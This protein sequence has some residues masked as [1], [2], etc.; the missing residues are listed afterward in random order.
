MAGSSAERAASAASAAPADERSWEGP[1]LR[2]VHDVRGPKV[3]LG[4]LWFA[5]SL[6]AAWLG[7]VALAALFGALAAVAALQSA[8]AWRRSSPRPHRIVAALTGLALPLAALAGLVAVPIAAL[9]AAL[10]AVVVAP[11]GV[12]RAGQSAGGGRAGRPRPMA[13][14]LATL[15]CGLLPA[16][17]AAAIVEVERFGLESLL[18]LLCLVAVY[19]AGDFLVGSGAANAVEGPL[20]GSIGVLVVTFTASV[21]EPAP[22]SAP[23]VWG[24]GI[25]TALIAP[26]GQLA[27]SAML[28]SGGSFA[29]ALRRIDSLLLVAPTWLVFTLVAG[30]GT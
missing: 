20:A 6:G 7:P 12:G 16:L 25:A 5:L 13:G 17:A 22:L 19:D 28:P 15:R 27:G 1:R 3:R 18:T 9:I 30:I 24:L 29:P 4:V 14:A 21:L 11:A 2:L 26:L 8:Y 23:Q 10:V